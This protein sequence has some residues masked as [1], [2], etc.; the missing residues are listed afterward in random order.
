MQREPVIITASA[1]RELKFTGDGDKLLITE[2]LQTQS[3]IHQQVMITP[4]E[5]AYI[6]LSAS[7]QFIEQFNAEI[8]RLQN[9][10]ITE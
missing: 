4:R 6:M 8:E 7:G 10:S 1:Y 3:L 5:L 9:Q 2:C